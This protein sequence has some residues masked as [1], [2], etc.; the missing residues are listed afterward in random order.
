[1]H[2]RTKESGPPPPPPTPQASLSEGGA[3]S[4]EASTDA[5]DVTIVKLLHHEAVQGDTR[6]R[7]DV[8]TSL[9]PGS[10][11]E[12]GLPASTRV[13]GTRVPGPLM[14]AQS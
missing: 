5:L 9:R 8:P 14:S 10:R 3:G 4:A 2:Q 7:D 1:M 12:R 11:C 13:S 6:R